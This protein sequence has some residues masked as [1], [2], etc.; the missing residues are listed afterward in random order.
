MLKGTDQIKIADINKLTIQ[1]ERRDCISTAEQFIKSGKG[2][3]GQICAFYGLRRTG[4]TTM[5]AQLAKELQ[6]EKHKCLYLVCSDE[7]ANIQADKEAGKIHTP[8]IKELFAILDEAIKQDVEY[9]FI[10]ELAYIKDFVGQGNVLSNYYAN[11]GLNILATGTDSLSFALAE[12]EGM[13]GRLLKI[14]TSYVPFAEYNRILKRNLD[15]YIE[16]GGTLDVPS[17]YK[18]REAERKYTNTSIVG[19]IVNSFENSEAINSR[20]ITLFYDR[21]DIIS[22]I[23]RCINQMNQ[24]FLVSAI[25]R[26]YESHPLHLGLHNA[27]DYPFAEYIDV[28]S[29]DNQVKTSLS[30]TDKEQMHTELKQKDIDLIRDALKELDLVETIPSYL[31]YK[32]KK[33]DKDIQIIS[34][35][36]MVYCHASELL[37]VLTDDQNWSKMDKCGYDRRDIFLNRIDRQ[38]K[39]DILE[40][41]ILYDTYKALGQDY[42]V[43]KLHLNQLKNREV[44]LIVLDKKTTDTYLFEIKYADYIDKSQTKNL[45]GREFLEYIE[46]NFGP[47]TGRYVIYNGSC[48]QMKDEIGNIEYISAEKFLKTVVKAK[49][50]DELLQECIKGEH[51]IHHSDNKSQ[52]QNQSKETVRRQNASIGE[53]DMSRE[54]SDDKEYT[55]KTATDFSLDK[56]KEFQQAKNGNQKSCQS[57]EKSEYLKK[58][59]NDTDIPSGTGY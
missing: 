18:N 9:V 38:V 11:Q 23:N 59:S 13:Y 52:S 16:G 33:K 49:N 55:V 10:D 2:T 45:S 35:A 15:D 43:S 41:M 6:N 30:I 47:I 46:E 50:I 54:K 39:G 28:L 27:G 19:N 31:S 56:F 36:G 7:R 21:D 14:H 26:V 40:N 48:G 37:K 25:N 32:S 58:H 1:N 44:D 53:K 20:S 24:D 57:Q 34:Q 42:Y 4:K 17:P 12:T 3:T 22:V 51:A 29:V 5:L 8:E